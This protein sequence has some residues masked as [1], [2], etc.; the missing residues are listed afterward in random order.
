[1]LSDGTRHSAD[2]VVGADGAWSSVRKA[3]S[4][5]EPSYVGITMVEINVS[6]IDSKYPELSTFVGPGTI[7]ATDDNK[8]TSS[9]FFNSLTIN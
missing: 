1:V 3:L 8:V 6:D 2:I 5:A 7:F 9:V 4:G